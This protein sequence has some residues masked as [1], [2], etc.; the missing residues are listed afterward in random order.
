MQ[1]CKLGN[2]CTFIR[3][4]LIISRSVLFSCTYGHSAQLTL[5]D[6]CNRCTSQT[7]AF[8]IVRRWN[9]FFGQALLQAVLFGLLLTDNEKKNRIF[10]V[11]HGKRLQIGLG[12]GVRR[13]EESYIIIIICQMR[14]FI[15]TYT[16]CTLSPYARPLGIVYSQRC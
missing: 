6:D 1:Q 7:R 15:G 11:N 13:P 14:L 2:I 4:N 10:A 16:I 8:P 5:N 9:H 12:T 3:M